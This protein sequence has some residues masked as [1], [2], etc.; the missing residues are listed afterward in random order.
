M[1]EGHH[2][3]G[4]CKTAHKHDINIAIELGYP[5]IA[6]EKLRNEPDRYKREQ[7]LRNARKGMYGRY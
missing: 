6:I 2:R 1:S 3:S 7:I 5:E 4:Y